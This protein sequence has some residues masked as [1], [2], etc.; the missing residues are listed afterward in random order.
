MG[1]TIIHIAMFL[2]IVLIF[3]IY[4]SIA[5][6][7]TRELDLEDFIKDMKISG[8]EGFPIIPLGTLENGEKIFFNMQ[9]NP[10]IKVVGQT[11][12]GKSNFLHNIILS[13]I[14]CHSPSEVKL[15][16]SDEKRVE[17]SE[18]KS[19]PHILSKVLENT[20]SEANAIKWLVWEMNRR[21]EILEENKKRTIVEYNKGAQE[22]M[23]FIFYIIDELVD[24]LKSKKRREISQNMVSLLQKGRAVGIFIIAASSYTGFVMHSSLV[25]VNFACSSVGFRM[26]SKTDAHRFLLEG[27]E[28]LPVGEALCCIYNLKKPVRVRIPISSDSL[29]RKIISEALDEHLS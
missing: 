9:E 2:L 15:V 8:K 22:K 1:D 21:Y 10:H 27:A 18:Y 4:F 20:D 13:L 24:L 29:K 14:S 23:P 12:S 11:G 7:K 26:N 5:F 19:L 28:K 3:L 6:L 25:A 16:L 17:F